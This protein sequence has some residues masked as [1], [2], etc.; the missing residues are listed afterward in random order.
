M[1]SQNTIASPP[2]ALRNFDTL[3]DSANVRIKIVA[4]LLGC[5]VSTAWRMVR[6]GKIPAPRKMSDRVT[7]FNV[8]ELRK[9]LAE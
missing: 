2:E 1:P 4:A 5:S 3:P 7:T 8:G 6:Q 9:A